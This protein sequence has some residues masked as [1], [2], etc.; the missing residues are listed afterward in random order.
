MK[1]MSEFYHASAPQGTRTDDKPA[2]GIKGQAFAAEIDPRAK[3]GAPAAAD[4][5]TIRR[6]MLRFH[7]RVGVRLALRVLAPAL[8]VLFA[9]FYILRPEF[10]IYFAEVILFDSGPLAR[11]AFS[12]LIAFAA[13]RAAAPR[14][15]YGLG[16]WMRHLP[17]SGPLVR[18]MAVLAIFIAQTPVLGVLLVFA[19]LTARQAPGQIPVNALGLIGLGFSA[20]AAAVRTRRRGPRLA[21]GL[22]AGVLCASGRWALLALGFALLG[23][24]DRISG[25]IGPS[26]TAPTFRSIWTLF[27]L[28]TAVAG[29]AVGPKI[30]IS[31]ALSGGVLVLMLAFLRNNPVSGP[32]AIAA[33]RLGGTLALAV[34]LAGAASILAAKRPPWPLA[35]TWPRSARRRVLADA[36]FLALP[37]VPLLIPIGLIEPRAVPAAAACLP[38][39]GL[40]AAAAVRLDPE[41]RFG[42]WAKVLAEGAFAA[43]VVCFEPLTSIAFLLLAGPALRAAARLDKRQKVSRWL[44]LHHLSAG[45]PLSWS[46]E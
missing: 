16:G 30:L 38:L 2:G 24:V 45:D 39:L 27:G 18:R 4:A 42:A 19:V 44:A 43:A 40:R 7:S 20:A 35:R 22:A 21:L 34:F 29:R 15:C 26:K 23:I 33:A 5:G 8:A 10:F 37:A 46:E 25:P 31:Y 32:T 9:L 28:P 6:A 12:A 3:P 1:P 36:L 17:S 13:A 41:L 14:I 11:G